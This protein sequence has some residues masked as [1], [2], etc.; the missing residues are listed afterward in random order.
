MT[1]GDGV[2]TGPLDRPRRFR[3]HDQTR[4]GV[5]LLFVVAAVVVRIVGRSTWDLSLHDL[6]QILAR[7]PDAVLDVVRGAF[8]GVVVV[9]VLW[10]LV[11][12]AVRRRIAGALGALVAALVSA[13]VAQAL[14]V[15]GVLIADP[16][17]RGTT[18]HLVLD[19]RSLAAFAGAVA[20]ARPW[21]GRGPRLA[22]VTLLALCA[23]VL[24]I[25]GGTQ[26]AS[27]FLA[28]TLGNLVGTVVL[29]VAGSPSSRLPAIHVLHDLERRGLDV[30]ALRVEPAQHGP[31]VAHVSLV[32]GTALR[33]EVLSDDDR[34]LD[35]FSRLRRT[36]MLR[37]P[38]DAQRFPQLRR[39]VE[40]EALVQLAAGA[41]GVPTP[42]P[43]LVGEPAIGWMHLGMPEPV[44]AE[45][46]GTDDLL[47]QFW[48]ALA[49]LQAA[50]IAHRAIRPAALAVTPDGTL[51]LQDFR[52]GQLAAPDTQLDLDIAQGLFTAALLAG[53]ERA[54]RS[55]VA[56]LGREQVVRGATRL[57]P[58]VVPRTARGGRRH[59]RQLVEDIRGEVEDQCRVQAL[60]TYQATRFS[61]RQAVQLVLLVALTYVALPLVAQLPRT[62]DAVRTADPVWGVLALVLAAAGPP[63]AALSL[64]SCTTASLPA[65]R[66]IAVQVAT[67]FVGTS[68]PA[69][70]GSLALNARYLTQTGR[71][72]AG[73]AG[74]VIALQ[75]VVQVVTHVGLLVLLAFVAG[76]ALDVSELVPGTSVVL[77][78]VALVLTLVGVVLAIPRLR[79][80][81]ASQVRRRTREV[82]SELRELARNPARLLLAVL[83]S[84]GVI[85]AGSLALWASLLAFGAGNE[86]VAA[87][88]VTMVGQ[89]L[90]TAA[91]TP[92]GVGAVE[93]ALIGGL[94]AFGVPASVAVPAVFF[95]RLLT[96]WIPVLAGYFV[97]RR[98][99]RDGSV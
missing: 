54:V 86:L 19:P 45:P 81:V 34:T 76:R 98:L 55:A 36:V 29:L 42:G 23:P 39:A 57:G 13:V 68:T 63:A 66:T 70:V 61:R 74:G 28:I 22:C 48:G 31:F 40:H 52:S 7:M 51:L 85:V 90:A 33:L 35:A 91:P 92:G 49:R 88:F 95:Y 5:A 46:E 50:R 89:T 20:V 24:L 64:R 71:L 15:A 77:L 25:A 69:S 32:D 94:A 14:V 21:L 6:A 73:A 44:G 27:L 96:C 4:V 82:V 3:T 84:C 80:T 10:V 87:A 97:L 41:A 17:L 9:V 18:L 93:A 59:S 1:D 79:R 60:E 16:V 72:T 8:A 62:I 11:G 56:R 43:L 67:S 30:T 12:L 75:S 37:R 2:I 58:V 65:G 26:L 78:V 83:G 99:Q 53:R 47:G 38:G